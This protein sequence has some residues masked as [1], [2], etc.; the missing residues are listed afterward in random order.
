MPPPASTGFWK[1]FGSY[2]MVA[3][4]VALLFDRSGS[5]ASDETRPLPSAKALWPS[6]CTLMVM[7]GAGPRGSDGRVQVTKLCATA[8]LQPSP[9]GSLITVAPGGMS[10]VTTTLLAV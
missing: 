5:E 10:K 9:K 3:T 2:S 6:G 4:A 8:Q 7:S 1:P